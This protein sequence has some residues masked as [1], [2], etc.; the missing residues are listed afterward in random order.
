MARPVSAFKEF[1]V[2][3]KAYGHV[4]NLLRDPGLNEQHPEIG[5]IV[6]P[7]W[8]YV[9]ACVPAHFNLPP[10]ERAANLIDSRCM[11]MVMPL[12]RSG[13]LDPDAY[14]ARLRDPVRFK[15][16]ISGWVRRPLTG[17]A[18]EKKRARHGPVPA[19]A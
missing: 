10:L 11:E 12:L 5:K 8:V 6:V 19:F 13:A 7:A 3:S 18:L 16:F 9:H 14:A 2:V 15:E 1:P 4:R 17:R